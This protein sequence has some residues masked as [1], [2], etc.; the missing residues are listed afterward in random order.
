MRTS[1]RPSKKHISD[2]EKWLSEEWNSKKEGFITDW[3][4]IPEAFEEDR[5]SV[6]T[7]D[8]KAIAFIVYRV[9][10]EMAVFDIA[11]MK[12][13]ERGKRQAK[14]FVSDTLDYLRSQ[15]VLVV[16][17]YC[18]PQNS[19]GFWSKCGFQKFDIP[20]NDQINMY[21][22]LVDELKPSKTKQKTQSD[23]IK[24]WD[25][26][27]HL[28]T[29][30]APRWIWELEYKED[31]KTLIKPIIFPA[32]YEWQVELEKID[33]KITHKIKYFPIDISETGTFMIIDKLENK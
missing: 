9:Y 32:F 11:E 17:L 18:S 27:P 14:K 20:H 7:K 3:E 23:K 28:A 15:D 19:E 22:T 30:N 6:L 2:I 21:K 24:L 26:E 12:P 10:D 4:M 1:F 33:K 8:E 29:R 5:L 31:Q 16:K 25:C 13:S